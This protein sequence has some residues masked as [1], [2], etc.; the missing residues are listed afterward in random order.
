MRT[1]SFDTIAEQVKRICMDANYDLS[2]N[3][4]RKF[5]SAAQSEASPLGKEV[6]Q[7]L[8]D[9]A[10]IA[11]EEEYPICQDTGDAVFFVELGQDVRIEGG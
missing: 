5:Q 8:I 7:Q 3:V 1:I 2:K 11:R 4:V 9:N 6:L 10:R